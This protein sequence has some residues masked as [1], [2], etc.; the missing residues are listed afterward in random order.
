MAVFTYRGMD[1]AGKKVSGIVDAENLKS[2]RLKLRKQNI[3][4]TQVSE[5]SSSASSSSNIFS[6][7][8]QRFKKVKVED[9]AMMTRQLST[10]VNANIP[11]VDA[12]TAM[13]DQIDNA[14]LKSAITD[15]KERVKEGARLAD[16]MRSHQDIFSDLYVNMIYAGEISGSLDTILLR[17]ADFTES[18]ARLRRKVTGAMI[19]PIIMI[20]VGVG[21]MGIVLGFLI[22]R[23]TKIFEKSK[24]GLPLPTEIVMGMSYII[25]HF[26]WLILLLVAL[27]YFL[28]S[29]Y[30]K[31]PKG[32]ENVDRMKLRLPVFGSIFRM[33]AIAR[34]SRTLSTL[35]NSGIQ[36]MKGLDICKD[37]VENVI[38]SNAIAETR[39]AVKEGESIAGP[40]R[41]SKQF[42]PMVLHMI[43]LGEKTGELEMMLSRVADTYEEQVDNKVSSLMTALEPLIIIVMGISV[44]F[45]AL[46]VMLPILKM[47][48]LMGG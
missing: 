35:M 34:F 32:H 6:S 3:Y 33:V 23:I 24:Q 7:L 28:Y 13:I 9:I 18:Q 27:A 31:S 29:R 39:V 2:A 16:A 38:L 30:R 21:L 11:L 26:W 22:P 8:I 48:E 25:V 36:L 43:A 46:S 41:R 4:P 5:G 10:L 1:V 20:T 14:Q 47:N 17:L 15:I 40:L 37:V 44:G 19:Y 42:P 45:I 12:L